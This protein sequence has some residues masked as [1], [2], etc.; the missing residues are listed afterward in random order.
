M[1]DSRDVDF[2]RVQDHVEKRLKTIH[3]LSYSGKDHPNWSLL[4]GVFSRSLNSILPNGMSIVDTVRIELD[5]T[6]R[7]LS[8]SKSKTSLAAFR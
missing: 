3:S 7:T 2:S 4:Y 1:L 5:S 6:S 8:Q